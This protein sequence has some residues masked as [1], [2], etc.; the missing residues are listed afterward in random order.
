MSIYVM[1]IH[2]QDN[3]KFKNILLKYFDL[4]GKEDSLTVEIDSNDDIIRESNR[5]FE[6]KK[7]IVTNKCSKNKMTVFKLK[8]AK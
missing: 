4:I 2:M 5:L 3:E 1:K 8:K 7:L 6:Q